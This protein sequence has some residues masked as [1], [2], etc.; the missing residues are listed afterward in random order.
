MTEADLIC[1]YK[2]QHGVENRRHVLKGVI[3]LV[4][5]YLKSNERIDAFAF[6]GY[7]AVLVH[8]LIERELRRAMRDAEFVELPLYPEDRACK[9]PTAARVIEIF[10]PLCTRELV[11]NGQILKRYDPSLSMS[12]ARFST[13]SRC[14]QLPIRRLQTHPCNSGDISQS[15]RGR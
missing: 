9:G 10:E 7:V 6:L 13:C 14:R 5:V 3:D 1:V 8:A 11:E 15:T 4:P 12:P 2:R